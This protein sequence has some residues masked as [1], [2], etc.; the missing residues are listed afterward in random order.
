MFRTAT[1]TGIILLNFL[2][3][4]SLATVH[5]VRLDGSGDFITIRGA[6]AAAAAGDTV[7]VGPGTYADSVTLDVALTIMSTDGSAAT[8][9]DSAPTWVI[10][11]G[12]SRVEGLSFRD[13][14]PPGRALRIDGAQATISDCEFNNNRA[15]EYPVP[16]SPDTGIGWGGGAYVENGAVVDFVRCRF[17]DNFAS[18]GG[19]AAVTT[20]SHVTLRQCEILDNTGWDYCAGV[21]VVDARLDVIG[22]LFAGN[23][24]LDTYE[25]WLPGG[26]KALKYVNST[27]SITGS[28]FYNS[29]LPNWLYS[30]ADVKLQSSTTV[31]I[32]RCIFLSE[33]PNTP[34]AVTYYYDPGP[35]SCNIYWPVGRRIWNDEFTADER[36]IDPLICDA[37]SGDFSISTDSPATPENSVCGELI[38]AFGPACS[39]VP[40]TITG[41]FARPVKGDVELSW[42]IFADEPMEGYRIYRK[43][44]AD[45]SAVA[46]HQGLIGVEERRFVDRTTSGGND[47]WYTLAVVLPGGAEKRSVTVAVKTPVA[48]LVLGQNVPNPFNPSTTIS[49]TLPNRVHTNLSIY[50]MEGKLIKTVTNLPLGA[51]LHEAEW[52]GTDARGVAVSSGIYFYRLEAGNKARTKKMLLLK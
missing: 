28:T 49:F 3:A 12:P 5:T 48:G 41:F 22:C 37:E 43:T 50:N 4:L 31:P 32:E 40:V 46:I 2:P 17:D 23:Q 27:G 44:A 29:L 11:A 42:E 14:G 13:M 20:G 33:G 18:E 26:T 8:I 1:I 21:T 15:P 39:L 9:V 38:G 7:E 34:Y 52:D 36:S 6:V 24:S 45:K 25:P 19:A 16:G 30:T 10:N 47:Y 51:G 35:R